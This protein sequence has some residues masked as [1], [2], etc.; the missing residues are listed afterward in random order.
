MKIGVVADDLTG[1]LDTGVQ[2]RGWGM[3]VAVQMVEGASAAAM[4]AE[5]VVVDTES[6]EDHPEE[7]YGKAFRAT[8]R[9]LSGSAEII[10]KKVDSTLRGNIGAELDAVMDASDAGMAFVAPAY[11]AHGRTT[12]EGIHLIDGRPLNETEYRIEAHIPTLIG[13]QSSRKVGLV[14]LE[15]V[16]RGPEAVEEEVSHLREEGVEV[17][18]FDSAAERDLLEVCRAAGGVDVFVGSAG[19]ASELPQGL[20]LREVRPALA[21]CGSTRTLTRRQVAALIERLGCRSIELDAAKL[22]NEDDYMDEVGRCAEKTRRALLAGFDVVVGSALDGAAE[23]KALNLGESLGCRETEVRSL[24]EEA[25]GAVASAVLDGVR[26]S[27]LILTGGATALSV[28]KALEVEDFEILEEVEPGIPLL[29]LTGG[30][31]AVTKAGG[32]G[33][34]DALIKIVKHLRRTASR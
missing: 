25:L 16:R 18:V 20:G 4:R 29:S 21:I 15:T 8:E 33:G 3:S 31:R 9:L 5:V 27:G 24:V 12:I 17:V 23:E 34:E 2:F 1:A 26:V 30:L 28:C 32:F 13:G 14:G 11:P 19:L 10:Y 7:A 6:R 22:F